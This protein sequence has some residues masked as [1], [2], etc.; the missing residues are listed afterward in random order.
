MAEY[1]KIRGKI[2][3]GRAPRKGLTKSARKKLG[4]RKTTNYERDEARLPGVGQ[5]RWRLHMSE[6]DGRYR[7][8]EEEHFLET[9]ARAKGRHKKGAKY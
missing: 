7:D 9:V 6:K 1:V 2:V 3:R 4:V 5:A 8:I